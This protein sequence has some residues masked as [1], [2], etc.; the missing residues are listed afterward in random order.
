MSAAKLLHWSWGGHFTLSTDSA[1]VMTTRQMM[2]HG[3][4]AE[5]RSR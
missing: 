3:L 2:A 1:G 4:D 5:A